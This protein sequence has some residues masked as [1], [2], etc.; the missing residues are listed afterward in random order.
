M[1]EQKAGKP[2]APSAG[3]R[4]NPTSLTPERKVSPDYGGSGLDALDINV[5]KIETN[6]WVGCDREEP[7]RSGKEGG[8]GIGMSSL[9][10]SESKTGKGINGVNIISSSVVGG[11]D[12]IT[13]EL[14]TGDKEEGRPLEKEEEKNADGSGV[15]ETYWS[16]N[17]KEEGEEKE[18]KQEKE[19]QNIAGRS[20]SEEGGVRS[21]KDISPMR[22]ESPRSSTQRGRSVTDG[23]GPGLGK[24]KVL[25]VEGRVEEN[26]RTEK[27]PDGANHTEVEK[28][29]ISE[30]AAKVTCASTSAVAKSEQGQGK[31][32]PP[33]IITEENPTIT[34]QSDGDDTDG[35]DEFGNSESGCSPEVARGCFVAKTFSPSDLGLGARRRK[36]AS[37][38]AMEPLTRQ[39]METKGNVDVSERDIR[40]VSLSSIY[41]LEE[42]QAVLGGVMPDRVFSITGMFHPDSSV[43][44]S[45]EEIVSGRSFSPY[46]GNAFQ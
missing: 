16:K 11:G 29:D 27:S 42:T 22:I 18:K 20:S 26:F 33:P 9:M 21:E 41:G 38:I 46:K 2:K 45:M 12:V 35:S 31:T 13:E 17:K 37:K 30:L 19:Q 6:G 40:K 5:V 1:A 36:E 14:E 10:T 25:G 28:G 23:P 4:T 32:R 39:G 43:K 7:R 44:V 8:G 24:A 3:T 34:P 15:R